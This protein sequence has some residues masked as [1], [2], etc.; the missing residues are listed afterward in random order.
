MALQQALELPTPIYLHTPLVHG[1]DGE[2]LSK[3]NG[4]QALDTRDPLASLQSAATVLGLS[5]HPG[6]VAEAL[7]FWIQQWALRRSA[8]A[9]SHTAPSENVGPSV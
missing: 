2:K 9:N 3:Q 4:A 5:A 6:P 8:A 1:L 7:G